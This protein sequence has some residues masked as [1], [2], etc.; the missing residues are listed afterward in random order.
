MKTSFQLTLILIVLMMGL[1]LQS[2]KTIISSFTVKQKNE[3]AVIEWATS[4]E[5][6]NHKFEIQRSFDAEDWAVIGTLA[7]RNKSL[8][9][10]NYTYTDFFPELG[11]NY[12][13]LRQ[14]NQNGNVTYTKK[15]LMKCAQCPAA[16]PAPSP[17][18]AIY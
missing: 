16:T 6:A 14:I 4:Q 9:Y 8:D 7:G 10:V 18:V 3:H 1:Q 2:Q 12:Y 17:V 13:R 11:S 5:L 15:L